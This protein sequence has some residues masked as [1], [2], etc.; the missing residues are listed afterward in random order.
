MISALASF[1]LG[2]FKF[3]SNFSENYDK[4][5]ESTEEYLSKN[6]VNGKV[7]YDIGNIE[8]KGYNAGVNYIQKEYKS[9]KTQNIIDATN[10][11]AVRSYKVPIIHSYILLL[12]GV[13]MLIKK[14]WLIHLPIVLILFPLSAMFIRLLNSNK[15]LFVLFLVPALLVFAFI[16]AGLI[17]YISESQSG[18][19]LSVMSAYIKTFQNFYPV[20]LLLLLLIF[21]IA[22]IFLFLFYSGNLVLFVFSQSG[23][24]LFIKFPIVYFIVLISIFLIF[25]AI[26]I[27]LVFTGAI[28]TAVVRDQGTVDS[29][30][31]SS[32]VYKNRLPEAF[33]I[34]LIYGMSSMT[35]VW[36]AIFYLSEF[37]LLSGLTI[38]VHAGFL[39][40]YLFNRYLRA[41]AP[42]QQNSIEVKGSSRLAFTA[43]IFIGVIGYIAFVSQALNSFPKIESVYSAW[44]ISREIENNSVILENKEG[45]YSIRYPK[46]WELYPWSTNSVTMHKN[47]NN[48]KSGEL[49]INIIIKQDFGSDFDRLDSVEPGTVISNLETGEDIAK[50]YN[51]IVDG[52]ETIK[53]TNTR[54]VPGYTEQKIVYLIKRDTRLHEIS[55]TA[56][57]AVFL[58][59]YSKVLDSIVSSVEFD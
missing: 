34:S 40:M 17:R 38:I 50:Q 51:M 20:I 23:L 6:I 21:I 22:S 36:L 46:D 7:F 44:Q 42:A 53:Y 29:W 37:A 59:E 25:S 19:K 48:T 35:A 30:I 28:Y 31:I 57:D 39:F 24:A 16:E 3:F 55:M 18:N 41:N 11:A 8:K 4:F 32:H 1:I 13:I 56:R 33:A 9:K 10:K 2:V 58:Q 54:L 27:F 45:G 52:F 5:Y 12:A 14:Y 15:E 26:Y 43:S 47:V 49:V